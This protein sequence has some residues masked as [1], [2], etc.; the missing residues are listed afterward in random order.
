MSIFT[1]TQLSWFMFVS[2]SVSGFVSSGSEAVT[3]ELCC[4]I[5]RLCRM[6]P[7]TSTENGLLLTS[8]TSIVTNKEDGNGNF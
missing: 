2:L 7:G 8:S 6:C 1:V 3:A 4:N 5:I